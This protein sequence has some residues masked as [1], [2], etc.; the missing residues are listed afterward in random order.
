MIVYVQSQLRLLL[1]V[2]LK[3][4]MKT[5]TEVPLERMTLVQS[6]V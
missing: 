2:V 3:V 4:M 5:S 1:E 6:L